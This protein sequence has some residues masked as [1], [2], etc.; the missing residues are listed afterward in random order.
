MKFRVWSLANKGLA[1]GLAL[2]ALGLLP[3]ESNASECPTVADP[4]GLTAQW[5]EQLELADLQQQLGKT[6]EPSENPLFADK[7]ASGSL[8]PVAQRLPEEPLVVMP[9]EECGKYGGTLRGLS[10]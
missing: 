2:T 9:Y 3:V 8:Q 4:K 10:K 6:I 1:A 7:V 5:P